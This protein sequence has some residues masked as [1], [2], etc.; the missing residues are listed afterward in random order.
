MADAK[1]DGQAT[2]DVDLR[3]FGANVADLRRRLDGHVRL[4][5]S[6]KADGYGFGAVAAALRAEQAGATGISLVDRAHALLIRKGGFQGDI[7]VYAGAP[8]DVEASRLA[9]EGDLILTVLSVDDVRVLAANATHRLRVAVKVEIG[10]ERVGVLPDELPAIV[11][12]IDA[13]QML[14]L[15]VVNAHPTL[16]DDA[17]MHVLEAQY[18]RFA[19][20]LKAVAGTRPGM[21]GLFASSKV[22]RRTD[23]M[24]FDA[25]DPGQM[26]FEAPRASSAIR[27]LSTRLLTARDVTR[28]FAPEWAPFAI[29]GVRRVGVVP[30]GKI[31][32]AGRCDLGV[33]RIAGRIVPFLGP[34][35]LEYWRVDLTGIPEAK[36]GDGVDIVGAPDD[37][38]IGIWRVMARHNMRRETDFALTVPDRVRRRYVG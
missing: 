33:C 27:R 24:A 29:D 8:I 4:F 5:A 18:A 35:S 15:A 26:L 36:A 10:A 14:T 1:H 7:L 16:A 3:A 28:D 13:S 9:G 38:D 17:P 20:A 12:A 2:L 25:V 23:A 34:P 32:G 21:V 6:V 22:L 31:D 37:P 11:R 19:S 30:Y